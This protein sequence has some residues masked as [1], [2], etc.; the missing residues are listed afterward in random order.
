MSAAGPDNRTSLH[1][2]KEN[3]PMKK[4]LA[5]IA[6]TI[7]AALL[8]LAAAPT[9]PASAAHRWWQVRTGSRPTNLGDPADARETQEV[10]GS[11][12]FGLIFAV[13]VEVAGE[14]VG[15]LGSGSLAEF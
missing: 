2:I 14:V 3:R 10:T 5:T 4:R 15:C 11:S 7:G 13:R 8:M 9:P 12:F 6:A 1:P